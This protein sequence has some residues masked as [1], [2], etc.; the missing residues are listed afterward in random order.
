MIGQEA[1]DGV[2]QAGEGP[3]DVTVA[4]APGVVLEKFQLP[5][6]GLVLCEL[7]HGC[8]RV[9][10]AGDRQAAC[11]RAV[12]QWVNILRVTPLILPQQ[13]SQSR[14]AHSL[15]SSSI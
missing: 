8:A 5:E 4:Q 14:Y 11:Q 13:T 9:R 12:W 1:V 2:L 6:G 3:L 15:V 7:L 10:S